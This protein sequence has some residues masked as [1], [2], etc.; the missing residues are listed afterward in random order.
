MC[1][2]GG[3][4]PEHNAL[5]NHVMACRKCYAPHGRYCP[6]GRELWLEY[7][8][9]DI[10]SMPKRLDRRATVDMVRANA[11]EWADEVERRVIAR[12][13]AAKGQK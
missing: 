10:V 2:V 8:V 6:D 5:I 4:Y 13:K 3:C 12:F 11:P 1:F 9:V 7:K